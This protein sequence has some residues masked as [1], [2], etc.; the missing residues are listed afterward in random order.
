MGAAVLARAIRVN[1]WRRTWQ[2]IQ[3]SSKP[4]PKLS[5]YYKPSSLV[6]SQGGYS[7]SHLD[8]VQNSGFLDIEH[9]KENW[10]Y[11]LFS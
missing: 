9:R 6:E 3:F 4:A 11:L 8:E 2:F 1:L 5:W 7:G 10:L